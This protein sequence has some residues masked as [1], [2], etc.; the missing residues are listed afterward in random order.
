MLLIKMVVLSV[1]MVIIILGSKDKHK[2]LCNSRMV[3]FED[4]M[5]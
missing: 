4:A 5:I 1:E 2:D 3:D